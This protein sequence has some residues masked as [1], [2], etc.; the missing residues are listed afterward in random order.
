[1]KLWF[2]RLFDAPRGI[3][4]E[5]IVRADELLHR[6]HTAKTH[7]GHWIDR[8]YFYFFGRRE[9]AAWL[10]RSCGLPWCRAGI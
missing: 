7:F 6:F 1:L 10:F 5:S 8:N 2:W 9:D 3:R 4:H